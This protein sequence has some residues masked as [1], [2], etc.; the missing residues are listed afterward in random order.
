MSSVG[1][2]EARGE[3]PSWGERQMGE[4]TRIEYEGDI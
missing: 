4:S 1:G 2:M 3:A